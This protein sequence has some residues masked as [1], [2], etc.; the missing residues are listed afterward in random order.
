LNEYVFVTAFATL[1][2]AFFGAAS[3]Y[4]FND[5]LEKR[6]TLK[7]NVANANR[8]LVSVIQMNQTLTFIDDFFVNKYRMDQLYWLNMPTQ[9]LFSEKQV[10]LNLEGLIFFIEFNEPKTIMMLA[11]LES[12]FLQL[13]A[14]YQKRLELFDEHIKPV[15]WKIVRDIN[16]HKI[17]SNDFTGRN[18]VS[19]HMDEYVDSHIMK[20]YI[21]LTDSLIFLNDIARTDYR[22]A[23]D[24]VTQRLKICFPKQKFIYSAADEKQY[25]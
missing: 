8:T 17:E 15:K 7:Q 22:N 9:K 5:T 18:E 19:I 10:S 25:Y 16:S 4:V 12:S 24:D 1:V 20:E 21:N 14:V 6:K 11:H 23:I 3:A 2:G 13:M